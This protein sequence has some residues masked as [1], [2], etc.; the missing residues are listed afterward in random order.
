MKVVTLLDY[1]QVGLWL[2]DKTIFIRRKA[3]WN[4]WWNVKTPHK[5]DWTVTAHI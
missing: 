1:V 2:L 3:M 5:C 4:H